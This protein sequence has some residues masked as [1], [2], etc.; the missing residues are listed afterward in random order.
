MTGSAHTIGP[1]LEMV[2]CKHIVYGSDCG[3]A[4]S[5]DETIL[6]NRAAM[7]NLACL[8]PEQVQFI[9]RNALNLFPRAAERLAAANRAVPQA[10]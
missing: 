10:L 9:G 5:S 8:T 6:A 1:A 2:G 4:C 3:V 7:L